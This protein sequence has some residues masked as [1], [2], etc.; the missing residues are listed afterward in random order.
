[1]QLGEGQNVTVVDAAGRR[2]VGFCY[3]VTPPTR[4]GPA[5]SWQAAI[6]FTVLHTDI[7]YPDKPIEH[8]PVW[9]QPIRSSGLPA[10]RAIE[11]RSGIYG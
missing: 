8:V 1:M 6:H 9:Q 11:D 5:E 2:W 3:A 7:P 4:D 10:V